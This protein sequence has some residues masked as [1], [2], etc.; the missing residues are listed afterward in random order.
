MGMFVC[1]GLDY[2]LFWDLKTLP[3]LLIT[4]LLTFPAFACLLSRVL[5]L[6]PNMHWFLDVCL[7]FRLWFYF[8]GLDALWRCVLFE[9]MRWGALKRLRG[10]SSYAIHG[11]VDLHIVLAFGLMY[12]M[13][14][15]WGK[16]PRTDDG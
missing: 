13:D 5:S 1:V 2:G 16:I 15:A 3:S 11:P 14:K 10:F 9:S 8:C 4:L 6:L 12:M 7:Q